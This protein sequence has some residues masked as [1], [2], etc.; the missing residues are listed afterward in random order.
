[1]DIF[2]AKKAQDV[3]WEVVPSPPRNSFRLQF[4]SAC[5]ITI[6]L[7]H[8]WHGPLVGIVSTFTFEQIVHNWHRFDCIV[9]SHCTRTTFCKMTTS[10]DNIKWFD[11]HVSSTYNMLETAVPMVDVAMY[12]IKHIKN[13]FSLVMSLRQKL[14]YAP[15]CIV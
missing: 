7:I 15:Y 6:P 10:D 2:P 11:Q 1:M 13:D 4:G 14:F 12:T 5:P 9:M 3:R 8:S